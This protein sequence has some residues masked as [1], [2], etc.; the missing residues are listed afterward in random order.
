MRLAQIST[1][2]RYLIIL[3]A[4]AIWGCTGESGVRLPVNR[5]TGLWFY[6]GQPENDF[7][8]AEPL[9]VEGAHNAALL[10]FNVRSATGARLTSA[11]LWL[12]GAG[13][14]PLVTL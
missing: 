12:H 1:V 3:P 5:D 11:R 6:R 10:G 2:V 7:G 4:L 9:F 14:D 13:D 8:A